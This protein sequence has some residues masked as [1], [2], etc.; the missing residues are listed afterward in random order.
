MPYSSQNGKTFIKQLVESAKPTTVLDVGAGSGTYAKFLNIDKQNLTAVEIHEPYLE[1]FSLMEYYDK[2]IVEDIRNYQPDHYDLILLGD[3]LEHMSVQEAKLVLEKCRKSSNLTIVSIP[4]GYYPQDEY[5]GN[6]YEKH[7]TDNWSHNEFIKIFGEPYQH[8]TEGEIG[9][10]VYKKLKICVYAIAKNESQFVERFCAAAQDADCIVIADTGSTDNTVT[11][12]RQHGAIVH[13]IS[14]QPWRFDHARNAALMLL[15]AD[16]DVCVSLDLDEELQPGWRE[17]IE[18]AWQPN[19]T[20]LRY[21]F[22]WGAG[23]VFYYEKIHHRKGYKWHHPCHEYPVPDSRTTEVW[24]TTDFL[25]A[26]HKPDPT[27]SR[28]QYMDLLELAVKED[29]RCPRNAFYYARELGFHNRWQASID[30]CVKYL[31]MPEATWENERCYAMRCAGRAASELGQ[32]NQAL[33]WFRLASAEAPYTREP[34]VELADC[35]YRLGMWEEC[36][37]AAVSALK[38]TD[39]QLVYT[40]DPEVWGAKT[41]DL[42][43]ISAYRLG[44]YEKAVEYGTDA[45]LLNPTDP[46]LKANINFYLTSVQAVNQ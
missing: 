11:L 33:K 31:D 34:W 40:V 28:G 7:V 32:W 8:H 42:A 36:Y 5:Q 3:I 19:T 29:P 17:A 10:Y 1:Q 45:M 39:K 22:D 43:A 21:K 30:A 25:I 20:R 14:V 15:P 41:P 6:P 16:I 23:I 9:V 24:A 26:V 44:L 35:C 13:E 4:L 38:I 27:K 37:A 12:S 18:A 46:R 2:I